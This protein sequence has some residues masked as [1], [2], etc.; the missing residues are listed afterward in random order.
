[1]DLVII[2]AVMV[3]QRF[4]GFNSYSRQIAWAMPYYQW[5]Q[6]RVS[7]IQGGRP[8]IATAILVLPLIASMIILVGLTKAILGPI[9]Y[10]VTS[11]LLLWYCLDARDIRKEPYPE[12]SVSATLLQSYSHCFALLFWYAL[13]GVAGLVL[14][15]S[16]AQLKEVLPGEAAATS[17]LK[18]FFETVQDILDWVPVRL[19]GLSYALV[20]HFGVV[21]KLWRQQLVQGIGNP[22]GLLVECGQAALRSETEQ[23]QQKQVVGLIDRSLLV[24]LVVFLLIML[25]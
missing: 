2:L 7:Q 13:L 18:T 14:Y 6:H 10:I 8:L 25:A 3:I 9:G 24:W 19:L 23:D 11:I 16:I 21:F 12:Q 5:M 4:L 15:F 20:G 17:A 22:R 1:V